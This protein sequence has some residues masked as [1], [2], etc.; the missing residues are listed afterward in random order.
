VSTDASTA[1][2]QRPTDE[3]RTAGRRTGPWTDVAIIVALSVLVVWVAWSRLEAPLG[4]DP[5][6]YLRAAEAWP[7]L[8]PGHHQLRVGLIWPLMAAVAV[9]GPGQ[10]AAQA[11]AA[12]LGWLFVVGGWCGLRPLVGRWA[13]TFAAV[14][15]A[16]H[17]FMIRSETYRM[18]GQIMPDHPA[19]GLFAAAVGAVVLA[20]RRGPGPRSTVLLVTAGLLIGGAYL[21]R[22]YAIAGAAVV[23]LLLH[24][25][26]RPAVRWTIPV[27]VPAALVFVAESVM[28]GALY[29]SPLA[30]VTTGASHGRVR[31][32][33]PIGR[34]DAATKLV[35]A[36]FH[37]NTW[38]AGTVFLLGLVAVVVLAW[39]RDREGRALAAWVA[40][41][42]VPITLLA[43]VLN[44]VRPLLPA[45]N[46]RYWAV[47]LPPLLGALGLLVVRAWRSRRD[48]AARPTV[49][50]G[51][52]AAVALLATSIAGLALH[53]Q[54]PASDEDFTQLRSFLRGEADTIVLLHADRWAATTVDVVYR[55][56]AV[57]GR[58]VWG[59]E[60]AIHER[61]AVVDLDALAAE[62][63]GFVLTSHWRRTPFPD[64]GSVDGELMFRSEHGLL[65]VHRIPAA[66]SA[67]PASSPSPASSSSSPSSPSPASSSS[68]PSPTDDGR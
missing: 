54:L 47:V 33:D 37:G 68:S 29:G 2:P 57:G 24:L 18:A 13:A 10:F 65:R 61:D 67:S 5:L 11:Y 1:V 46:A 41:F 9:V 45:G 66:D 14:T 63:G 15:L 19:A 22:E 56:D 64:V 16:L 53:A 50:A 60:L 21:V 55:R 17:P 7:D 59:G 28:N 27:A 58:V 49:V 20:A 23:P 44:P 31:T 32:E 43:G 6:Y 26:G 38:W 48:R 12:A 62:G 25:Y 36:F 4:S 34:L 51:G 8:E 39:R 3:V 52:V 30:R 35:Q 40:A 42:V